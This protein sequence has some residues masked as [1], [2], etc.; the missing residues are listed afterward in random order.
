[1]KT[2]TLEEFNSWWFTNSVP[3]GLLESYHRKLFGKLLERFGKRWIIAITGLRRVGKTT[4]IYQLIDNLLK[5]TKPFHIFYFSFDEKVVG[6]DEVLDTYREYANVDFRKDIIYCFF[7]EIQKLNNWQNQIKKY[8]DLYP[9]LRFIVSGSESLFLKKKV[10]ESLAGRISDFYL[11]TLSFLEFL[12][13]QGVKP[14][15][16]SL[17]MKSQF[18]KY[19]EFGGFPELV[20]E[21]DQEERK[22]YVKSILVD[23]I[24]YKDIPRMYK[25]S[26]PNKLLILIEL[27]ATNPGMYVDYNSLSQQFDVDRRSIG[28]YVLLLKE[29]FL[30]R[31][32]GNFRKGK[33]AGLRKL[34][35]VYVSDT[36]IVRA[37][38]PVITE[39]L[40]G[41]MVE[42]IVVNNLEAESFWK[43]KY[44]VDIISDTL[45]I[46]VKY[47]EKI[48]KNDL[49]GIRAFMKTFNKTEGLILSKNDE[50]SI[51]VS[52]GNITIMPVW[53]YLLSKL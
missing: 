7:D 24:I 33:T 52:E 29:A 19:V 43:K 48:L 12:E 18:R 16:Y 15:D 21:N 38:N 44:E 13:M 28:K 42:T 6:L 26:D 11:S 2:S 27:F 3:K 9:N 51:K 41:R 30:I 53:K 36:A 22:K 23:K 1:M 5:T 35:R 14:S 4:I 32:L 46:E 31:L 45:P 49:K 50:R 8:Y 10:K 40:F 25:I 39:E 37:F 47:Q 17:D 34:K 20:H